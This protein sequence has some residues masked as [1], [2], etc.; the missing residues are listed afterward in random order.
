[1]SLSAG[2]ISFEN[3]WKCDVI[4]SGPV[5]FVGLIQERST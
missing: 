4:S 3:S 2:V 1:M 5:A